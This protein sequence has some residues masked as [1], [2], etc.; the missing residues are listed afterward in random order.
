MMLGEEILYKW[1]SPEG[2]NSDS[3][4]PTASPAEG[5]MPFWGGIE[6]HVPMFTTR[7]ISPTYIIICHTHTLYTH[8]LKGMGSSEVERQREG[9]R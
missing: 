3:C 5:C 2:T 7:S 1:G 6:Q 8:R 4:Q 9:A